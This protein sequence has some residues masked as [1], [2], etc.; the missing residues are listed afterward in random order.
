MGTRRTSAVRALGIAEHFCVA[1][2]ARVDAFHTTILRRDPLTWRPAISGLCLLLPIPRSRSPFPR[3]PPHFTRALCLAR[4]AP[5]KAATARD[6]LVQSESKRSESTP[7]PDPPPLPRRAGQQ[8]GERLS[9]SNEQGT[10]PD[11]P[12]HFAG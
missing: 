8:K 2:R 10:F 1:A 12:P 11:R 5:P 9:V 4:T 3:K 7:A 6:V